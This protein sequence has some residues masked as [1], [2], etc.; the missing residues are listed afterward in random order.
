MGFEGNGP[1]V[2]AVDNLPAEMPLES[3]VFFSQT[4][5]PFLPALAAADF[6]GT[7]E[8]CQLPDPIKRAVI[9]FRGEFPPSYRY[10]Q[11]FV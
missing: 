9:L 11:E 3:S 7:F 10:M 6:G 2:L 1:V 4:L 8:S 5:R